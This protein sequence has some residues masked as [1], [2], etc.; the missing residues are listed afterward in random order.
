MQK[1]QR[2]RLREVFRI[3]V[4]CG[5]EV[6]GHLRCAGAFLDE[7]RPATKEIMQDLLVALDDADG[8]ILC[9]RFVPQ[10]NTL[11]QCSPRS[12]TC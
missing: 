7:N 8:R 4:N 9:A 2:R 6:R 12:S 1:A 3:G 11:R 10:E 5:R